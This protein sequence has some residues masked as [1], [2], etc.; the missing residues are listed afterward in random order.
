M[1]VGFMDSA[2]AIALMRPSYMLKEWTWT[3]TLT[4]TQT[5]TLNQTVTA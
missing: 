3:L 4:L 2:H 1:R 5:V